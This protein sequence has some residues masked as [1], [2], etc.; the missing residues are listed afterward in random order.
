MPFSLTFKGR[1]HPKQL[2]LELGRQT[3]IAQI[4]RFG[5]KRVIGGAQLISE[6]V[7]DLIIQS[8]FCRFGASMF[9]RLLS[10]GPDLCFTATLLRAN[11]FL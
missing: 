6:V 10:H 1:F 11:G 4:G 9:W 7:L 5:R 2:V 3:P 8:R